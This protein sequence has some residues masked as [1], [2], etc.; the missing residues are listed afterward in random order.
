MADWR[1]ARLSPALKT[2]SESQFGAG[3]P[4]RKSIP[5]HSPID[6]CNRLFSGLDLYTVFPMSSTLSYGTGSAIYEKCRVC[7]DCFPKGERQ[8]PTTQS[9]SPQTGQ[10]TTPLK[11]TVV[12]D[13]RDY[14]GHRLC[15]ILPPATMRRPPYDEFYGLAA[16]EAEVGDHI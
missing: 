12:E 3:Q 11:S 2:D 5:A 4:T 13:K 15:A 6:G 7:K 16:A 1:I 8:C 10:L 14:I 9:H